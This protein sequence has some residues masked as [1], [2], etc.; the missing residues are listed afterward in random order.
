MFLLVFD[1]P[2]LEPGLLLSLFSF[3]NVELLVLLAPVPPKPLTPFVPQL[4]PLGKPDVPPLCK[5]W[6]VVI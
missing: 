2:E 6:E 5:G 3:L 4:I 1:V